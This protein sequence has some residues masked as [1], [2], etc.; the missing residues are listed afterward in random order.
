MVAA[1]GGHLDVVAFLLDRGVN[2]E[3]ADKVIRWQ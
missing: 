2:M 1:Y 3:A